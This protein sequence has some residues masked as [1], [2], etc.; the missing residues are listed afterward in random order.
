MYKPI[1]VLLVLIITFL[2]GKTQTTF[3]DVTLNTKTK[4]DNEQI[5]IRGYRYLLS[6]YKVNDIVKQINVIP[7]NAEADTRLV[8]EFE[9]NDLL[10]YINQYFN[11]KLAATLDGG[12]LKYI[13]NDK[14]Y[15]IIVSVKGCKI[16]TKPEL[17]NLHLLINTKYTTRKLLKTTNFKFVKSPV[18]QLMII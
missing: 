17:Y 15:R 14:E 16:Q 13:H 11:I 3:K 10:I 18:T 2:Q 6:V 5:S 8:Y 9:V 7:I 1:I 4:F 12:T